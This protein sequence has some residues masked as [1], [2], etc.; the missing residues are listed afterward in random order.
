MPDVDVNGAVS[1]SAK[2]VSQEENDEGPRSAAAGRQDGPVEEGRVK[3]RAREIADAALAIDERLVVEILVRFIREEIRRAGFRRAV[4]G[5]SG[6][7]DSSLTAW[8]TAQALGPENVL[9]V[10]MP[11]RESS[12]DSLA[13]A[14]LVARLLGIE[15]I[16]VPITD[17][18]DAYFARFP[19]ASKERRANKMAR[20]RMTILYDLSA[21]TGGLVVGTSNKTELLLGYGTL[22]GD[23]AY[24]LNPLADLYKTQ[25]WRVARYVGVPE[26]IV[27]KPP[28]ADLWVGQTDEGELG[29]TYGDADRALV[30][31]IDKR[32]S[33][34]HVADLGVDRGFAVRLLELVRRSQYKR[35]L[36]L[37]AKISSRTVGRDFRYSRDWG[38]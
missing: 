21:S 29:F 33:I 37:F 20:E 22:Y 13:H 8:L 16:T 38:T 30:L 28:T 12:P 23:L 11:Y 15:L 36:P 19:N 4:V 6:G 10:R 24:A 14:E 18:I 27:N 32:W 34:E 3:G 1:E 25:V 35:S 31:M 17:Q 2:A 7:V 9:G 26:E 5:L